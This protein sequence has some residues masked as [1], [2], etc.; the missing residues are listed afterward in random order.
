MSKP[1]IQQRTF[2]T[3]P[4]GRAGVGLLLLRIAIGAELAWCSYALLSPWQNTKARVAAIAVLILA[5]GI[6]LTLGFLTMLSSACA[7]LLSLGILASWL[8]TPPMEVD[9][10]R[11]SSAF[12][13]I[14]ALSLAFIGPGAFSI[15]ARRYGR[16][17]IVIPKRPPP[18]D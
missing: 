3:F 14:I 11:L 4:G 16:R 10:F 6:S 13:A 9:A 7:A 12:A 8:P 1:S 18:E 17:E 2:S 5:S 15:D